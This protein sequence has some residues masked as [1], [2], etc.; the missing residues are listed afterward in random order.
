MVVVV[1]VVVVGGGGGGG[2][3]V[4]AAAAIVVAWG[5]GAVGGDVA[6]LQFRLQGFNGVVFGRKCTI[7]GSLHLFSS[8]GFSFTFRLSIQDRLFVFFFFFHHVVL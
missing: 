4:A 1:V 2:V 6:T 7:C 3:A 8:S 5:T